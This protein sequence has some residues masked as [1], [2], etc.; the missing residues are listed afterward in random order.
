MHTRVPQVGELQ[1]KIVVRKSQR[2]RAFDA[3][4][5]K[6]AKGDGK[7]KRAARKPEVDGIMP[8]EWAEAWCTGQF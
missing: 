2:D 5:S 3:I 6:L 7:N 4:E 8:A 1:N